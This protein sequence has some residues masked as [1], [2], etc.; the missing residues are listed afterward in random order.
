[1][2]ALH[3]ELATI[4]DSALLA[5]LNL[6]LIVDEGHHNPMNVMELESRMRGWL[7]ADYRAVLFRRERRVVAY[8][9]FRMDEWSRI[10]LRQ[11]FV[12]RAA[13]RQGVGR[14][15]IEIFKREVV[16]A[17]TAVV[18]EVLIRN[19]VGRAFWAATGFREYCLALKWDPGDA[20]ADES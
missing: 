2:S 11:F 8:A 18:L 19:A 3:W 13:R 15:A 6:E 4:D 17:G 9:L 14:T 16:P 10:Y 20:V 12:V 7:S 5:Q 1:M